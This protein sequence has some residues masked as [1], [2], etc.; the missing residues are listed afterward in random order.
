[1]RLAI[2]FGFIEPYNSPFSLLSLVNEKVLWFIRL[3]ISLNLFLTSE[4]F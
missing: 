3:E 1:M 4:L 2:S